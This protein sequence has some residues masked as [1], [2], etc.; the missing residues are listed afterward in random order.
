MLNLVSGSTDMV[1]AASKLYK[2]YDGFW[3]SVDQ[4]VLELEP[5]TSRS[6]VL[7]LGSTKAI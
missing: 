3:F 4:I 5:K 7:H 6:V 1:C 2:Y